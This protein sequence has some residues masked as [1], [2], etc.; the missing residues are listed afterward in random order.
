[1]DQKSPGNSQDSADEAAAGRIRSP[2]LYPAELR[3]QRASEDPSDQERSGYVAPPCTIRVGGKKRRGPEYAAYHD[4]L[5][6]CTNSKA[7]AFERYGGRGIRVCER[8]QGPGGFGRFV[9]DV[10]LR[11]RV[12][13]SLDRIDNDGNYE[14]DNC[15]WA[16][17]TRQ[18]RNTRANRRIT[19]NGETMCVAAWAERMGVNRTT[20]SNRLR[21]GWPPE[22]AVCAPVGTT[23]R[24]ATGANRWRGVYPSGKRWRAQICVNKRQVH[25]GSFD[26]PEEAA[27]AYDSAALEAFGA[28][29]VLNL[30]TEAAS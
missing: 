7:A 10:G 5:Q 28:A 21:A 14:P 18:N 24:P 19:I 4:M 30:G 26:T 13:M 16:S 1:M 27:R 8:W 2:A 23:L 9:E 22:D 15:R 12:G 29:A 3:A 20:I 11:P 6:R 17:I 25:L